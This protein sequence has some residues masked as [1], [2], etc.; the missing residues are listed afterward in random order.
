MAPG[1]NGFWKK[2]CSETIS[3]YTKF[4]KQQARR[5]RPFGWRWAFKDS[6]SFCYCA[7]TF[8]TSQDDLRNSGSYGW[9]LLLQRYFWMVFDYAGNAD[10]YMYIDKFIQSTR[11]KNSSL[12]GL[13][14]LEW[15]IGDNHTLFRA[16][17]GVKFE[18]KMPYLFS[19][20]S[21]F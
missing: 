13:L 3:C 16:S 12:Q 21:F 11:K 5:A 19:V 15:K 17:S 6:A 1:G 18:K 4:I 8:C 14:E 9:Y 7:Y 20:L 10:T 2:P